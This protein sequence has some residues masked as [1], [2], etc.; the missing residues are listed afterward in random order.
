MLSRNVG[1]VSGEVNPT[2]ESEERERGVKED[3]EC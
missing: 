2:Q 1:Y 3:G